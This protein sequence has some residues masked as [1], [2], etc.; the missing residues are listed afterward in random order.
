MAKQGESRLSA[1]IIARVR[2]RG[3]FAFKVQAGPTM[4]A[5]L[6]DIVVCWRGLFVGIETKMPGAEGATPIQQHVHKEIRDV[7]GVVFVVRSVEE[8]DFALSQLDALFMAPEVNAEAPAAFRRVDTQ[9]STS[10]ASASI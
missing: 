5:G 9:G 10:D 3:G 4:R 7:G 1:R 6:P 8:V 2:E